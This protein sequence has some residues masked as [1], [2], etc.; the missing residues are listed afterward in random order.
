MA[1]LYLLLII[2]FMLQG[3]Y[4]RVVIEEDQ[5]MEKAME[6]PGSAEA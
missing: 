3:G 5:A 2:Y 4:K 1:V 6:T